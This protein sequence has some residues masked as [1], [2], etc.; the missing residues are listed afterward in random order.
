SSYN[1]LPGLVKTLI[2]HGATDKSVNAFTAPGWG[3]LADRVNDGFTYET[4]Q[5]RPW[6]H[7][8]LQAQK[9]STTGLYTYPT[10]A[11]ELWIRR[12]KEHN[13]IPIMFPEWPRKLNT[14]EG[15]RVHQLHMSIAATEPACVA[16]IGLTWDLAIS[17]YPHLEFHATDGNHSNPR[18]TLLT[19]YVFYEVIT[20][21]L[22]S[23]LPFIESLNFSAEEQQLMR[24]TA[25][26]VIVANPPCP[27]P[28]N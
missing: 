2:E 1:N 5:A 17:R 24:E 12:V 25:S 28:F 15:L 23:E 10:S 11:A 4:I 21:Q 13:A 27:F 8:S 7:I 14:E 20:E 26:E 22:A 16:P 18:G 9:Y 19:A 3:F 6:T